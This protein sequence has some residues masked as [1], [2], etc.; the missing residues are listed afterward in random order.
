MDSSN[1][2]IALI[3]LYQ[4]E[5]RSFL[6]E[7]GFG[8]ESLTRFMTHLVAAMI[9]YRIEEVSY[10]PVVYL[11]DTIDPLESVLGPHQR[12][13][14]GHSHHSDAVAEEMLLKGAPLSTDRWK[15]YICAN[16]DEFEYGL[17][18][19]L[20]LPIGHEPRHVLVN[21]SQ[22]AI[23]VVKVAR[24]ANRCLELE[25]N[26][27]HTRRF[28]FSADGDI[29]QSPYELVNRIASA[30]VKDAPEEARNFLR[31]YLFNSIK[32]GILGSHGALIA[33]VPH[34]SDELP[35][36][37]T[38]AVRPQ[39]PVDMAEILTGYANPTG[40]AESRK[41][42]GLTE[43]LTG[44]L[45]SDGITVFRSDGTL[46][47][48]RAFASVRQGGEIIHGGA[49]KRAYEAL[50]REVRDGKSLRA[51]FIHTQDGWMDTVEN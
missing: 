7:A 4:D 16:G 30:A 8:E 17:F 34:G 50:K 15:L 2:H 3:N 25:S 36:C 47:A 20:A 22:R 12:I 32:H 51:A 19:G 45:H 5:V 37:F 23:N 43:L 33:V 40:L 6:T 49:R 9:D 28:F 11:F 35:S 48:Y 24:I 10:F 13:C 38:D 46:L 31:E 27:A 44:A 29:T 21:H 41:L 1:R 39:P 42:A 26:R 14:L 18:A